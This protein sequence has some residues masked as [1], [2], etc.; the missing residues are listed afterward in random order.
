MIIKSGEKPGIGKYT[1]LKCGAKQE[2]RIKSEELKTCKLC[3]NS[4]FE[5]KVTFARSTH[6]INQKFDEC[7][8]ILEVSIFLL[9]VLKIKAFKNV[10]A[11]QLRL[12][13]CDWFNGK[14]ISLLPIVFEDFKFHPIKD[15][16][17]NFDDNKE[18]RFVPASFLFDYN[19]DKIG[20]KNWLE[21]H[22]LYSDKEKDPITIKD[23]IRYSAN[24]HGGA[25]LDLE[26]ASN[27]LFSVI[28]AENYLIK[29]GKYI[30]DQLDYDY[31]KDTSEKLFKPFFTL[32]KNG[33][34]TEK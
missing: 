7:I 19:A 25:H 15:E 9:D 26:L 29:I 20:I 17:I 11:L 4:N 14:N 24:K 1:C 16:Y 3:G 32:M 5:G 28:M 22:I 12:L 21:Q 6:G 31:E 27:E 2:L 33:N 34:V 8:T 13:L 10:L 23:I 18:N 30:L